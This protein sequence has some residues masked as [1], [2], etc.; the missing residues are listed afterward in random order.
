MEARERS[1]RI[2]ALGLRHCDT[3]ATS[4]LSWSR[5]VHQWRRSSAGIRAATQIKSF[6]AT[7]LGVFVKR[8]PVASLLERRDDTKCLRFGGDP[9]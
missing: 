1:G 2:H 4:C 7:G 9:I 5:A 8:L 3:P 6:G